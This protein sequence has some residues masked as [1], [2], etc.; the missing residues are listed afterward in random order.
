MK[1]KCLLYSF[2]LIVI[3]SSLYSS[4]RD[5]E[6][7]ENSDWSAYLINQETPVLPVMPAEHPYLEATDPHAPSAVV[8]DGHIIPLDE[9]TRDFFT[10]LA[11][12]PQLPPLRPSTSSPIKLS[13]YST[14]SLGTGRTIY[15][16]ENNN[17]THQPSSPQVFLLPNNIQGTFTITFKPDRPPTTHNVPTRASFLNRILNSF[18]G[19]R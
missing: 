2:A 14:P 17:L 18:K 13:T 9:S 12:P 5:Y 16:P 19:R 15:L 7:Q 4:Q 6:Y 11:T 8:I 3:F 10:H 1:K